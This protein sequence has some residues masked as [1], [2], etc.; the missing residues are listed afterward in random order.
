[1]LVFLSSLAVF[2]ASV[3][4]AGAVKALPPAELRRQARADKK[5]KS[6]SIYKLVGYGRSLDIFLGLLVIAS[7]IGSVLAAYAISWWLVALVFVLSL[8]V[9]LKDPNGKS[10]KVHWSLAGY[11]AYPADWLLV[12]MDPLFRRLRMVSR[13]KPKRPHTRAYEK[14]DLL[15]LIKRQG[16]Q[17]DN[18]ISHSDLQTALAALS[19]ADKTVAS[20]MR[21]RRKVKLVE[22]S[23]PV[24]PHL[25]DELHDSGQ[26]GFPVVKG[27][28]KAS[29]PE[30]IGIL[31]L[32]DIIGVTE[33]GKVSGVM[34]KPVSYIN[35]RQSL[36]D[37][38][39]AF[40]KT[41]SHLL[42]VVNNFEEI[43]GTLTFEDVISQLVGELPDEGF[44]N[45]DN[46]HAVAG[47]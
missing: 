9:W 39:L 34:K 20:V 43:V 45:Y 25:M 37:A 7:F 28:A 47:R 36:S 40:S 15:A 13:S 17:V 2:L 4:L 27:S 30:I 3:V 26:T 11:L 18:R 14:E 16:T 23:E 1:M 38:L 41:R 35:E 8:L 24:G 44:E 42:V 12:I 32:Q 31:Y 33:G 21:P 5:S 29:S 6:A 10:G 46:P 19:F 22:A